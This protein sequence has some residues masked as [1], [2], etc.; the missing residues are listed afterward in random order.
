M[1]VST[2]K[3]LKLSH[4]ANQAFS[5]HLQELK[6]HSHYWL[7]E[8]RALDRFCKTGMSLF[9]LHIFPSLKVHLFNVCEHK[10]LEVYQFSF[11]LVRDLREHHT[12]I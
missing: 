3:R 8:E 11:I 7:E 4:K 1:F 6:I 10:S 9:L 2:Y 12:N 5:E